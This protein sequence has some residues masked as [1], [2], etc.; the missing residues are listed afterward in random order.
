VLTEQL[1]KDDA[2]PFVLA[3]RFLRRT[4]AHLSNVAYSVVN[5]FDELPNKEA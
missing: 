4:S 2:V 3:A 1:I 5:P